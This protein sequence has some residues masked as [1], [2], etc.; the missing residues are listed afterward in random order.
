MSREEIIELLKKSRQLLD[1]ERDEEFIYKWYSDIKY[2]IALD[3]AI[4]ILE[5]GCLNEHCIEEDEQ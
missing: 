2:R 3:E 5:N 4:R 1:E